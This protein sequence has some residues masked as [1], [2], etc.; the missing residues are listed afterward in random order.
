MMIFLLKNI[1]RSKAYAY[2]V[3]YFLIHIFN[4]FWEYVYNILGKILFYVWKLTRPNNTYLKINKNKGNK[5]ISG[6]NELTELANLI[7]LDLPK[8]KLRYVKNKMIKDNDKDIKKFSEIVTEHLS[9]ET[10]KKIYDFS[11]SERVINTVVNYL[12]VFPILSIVQV[13]YNIP[14][15]GDKLEGSKLWHQDGFGY[16]SLDFFIPV[17]E[18]DDESGPLYIS[19]RHPEFGIFLKFQNA[20]NNKIPWKAGRVPLYEFNKIYQENQISKL[21]GKIGNALLCDSFQCYHR[22]GA[23]KSKDRLMLRLSYQTPDAI[24]L[25]KPLEYLSKYKI[26]G[27]N[28]ILK[29]LYK[30]LLFYRGFLFNEKI[31]ENFIHMYHFLTVVK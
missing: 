12:G 5:L 16:K 20:T 28:F 30:Y 23:C 4:F 27:N 22:G 8:E 17:T 15:D 1:K 21:H 6:D 9:E 24:R 2:F 14:V 11:I 19:D 13:Y 10:C 31:K 29:K 3:K 26:I 7:K 18:V 25:K